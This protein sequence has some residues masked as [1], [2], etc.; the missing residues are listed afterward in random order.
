MPC[1][2]YS[3]ANINSIASCRWFSTTV[4]RP[5][6]PQAW[7]IELLLRQGTQ[8]SDSEHEPICS[9]PCVLSSHANL[10][11]LLWKCCYHI[12]QCK[13]ARLLLSMYGDSCC[14]A[15]WCRLLLFLFDFVMQK[16]HACCQSYRPSGWSSKVN[17]WK[18]KQTWL[19][20][21]V[22]NTICMP[23]APLEEA[24]LCLL[25]PTAHV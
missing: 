22:Q 7:A 17:T 2:P 9:P 14:D 24:V 11:S 6:F 10:Q 25:L 16:V 18:G 15:W 23:C 3:T 4:V 21:C 12:L 19:A 1:K 5:E 20:T 13:D 8:I